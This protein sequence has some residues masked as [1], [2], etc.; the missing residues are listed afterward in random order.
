MATTTAALSIEEIVK[1]HRAQWVLL[2]TPKV[3]ADR[4][5]RGGKVLWHGKDRD[6][7]YGMVRKLRPKR[8]AMVYTGSIPR[9]AEV[10]L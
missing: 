4:E 8:F 10:A 7:G 2:G 5:V 9:D 6:E 1:Q 3:G